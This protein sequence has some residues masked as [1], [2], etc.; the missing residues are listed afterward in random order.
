MLVTLGASCLK[1]L[2]FLLLVEIFFFF[3]FDVECV[4]Y[5]VYKLGTRVILS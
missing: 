5:A 1:I 3:F 4:L 2:L